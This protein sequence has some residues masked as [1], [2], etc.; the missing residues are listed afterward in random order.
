MDVLIKIRQI[1]LLIVAMGVL[2]GCASPRSFDPSENGQSYGDSSYQSYQSCLDALGQIGQ[3]GN[4]D[5]VSAPGSQSMNDYA[6]SG[7]GRSHGAT[8]RLSRKAYF[9]Y[10][11]QL[12]AQ[13]QFA[14]DSAWNSLAARG[15]NR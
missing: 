9:D 3:A 15:Q 1:G 10:V 13:T 12:P 6:G 14:Q 5:R 11:G 2:A 8:G 7:N 4:C